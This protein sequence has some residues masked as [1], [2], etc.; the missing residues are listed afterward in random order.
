MKRRIFEEQGYEIPGH[1]LSKDD[2]RV[3]EINL[4]QGRSNFYVTSSGLNIARL[5]AEVYNDDGDSFETVE[6]KFFWH[7]VP[8]SVAYKYTEDRELVATA[9]ALAKK[10]LEASSVWY[11]ADFKGNPMRFI[12]AAEQLRRQKKKYKIYYPKSK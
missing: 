3:F 11:P 12:C 1:V 4:R 9:K 8:K 10:G 7:H 2:F 6:K 5:A